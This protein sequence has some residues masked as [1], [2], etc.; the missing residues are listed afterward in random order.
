MVQQVVAVVP[1][2]LEQT[3]ELVL[4]E[5]VVQEHQIQF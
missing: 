5:L 1:L 3:L 2:L 4:V